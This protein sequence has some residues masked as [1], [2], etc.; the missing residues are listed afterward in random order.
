ML[1]ALGRSMP[2]FLAVDTFT[3]RAVLVDGLIERGGAIQGD[4]L[5]SSGFQIDSFDTAFAEG[6]LLVLA[7]LAGAR[8]KEQRTA[9]ALSA[10]PIG[11]LE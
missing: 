7:G 8:W 9:V 5:Q 6:L 11:V 4:P 2:R 3:G 1:R 10:I